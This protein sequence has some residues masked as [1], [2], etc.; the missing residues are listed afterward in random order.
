MNSPSVNDLLRSATNFKI[1][2]DVFTKAELFSLNFLK[3]SAVL[4]ILFVKNQFY[5]VWIEIQIYQIFYFVL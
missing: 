3:I 2:K 5:F 1:R 4:E